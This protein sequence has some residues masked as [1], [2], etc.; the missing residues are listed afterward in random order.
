M[1]SERLFRSR[2]AALALAAASALPL[3]AAA[4]CVPQWSGYPGPF[5][6]ASV[7]S[8]ATWD[9]DGAAPRPPMIIAAGNFHTAGSTYLGFVGL[10]DGSQWVSL[11]GGTNGTADAVATYT[12]GASE[13]PHAIFGGWFT[14]A[15]GQTVNGL[16]RFDGAGWQSVGG[17]V[18]IPGSSFTPTVYV[19][20]SHDGWLI[21]SGAFTHA[22]N[23]HTGGLARW[24]GQQWHAF[25]IAPDGGADAL[26]VIDDQLYLGG[27]F[28]TPGNPSVMT[29]MLRW[30]GS[31]WETIGTNYPQWDVLAFAKYRGHLFVGGLFTNQ[32]CGYPPAPGEFIARLDGATWQPVGTGLNGPVRA[33]TVFDPDGPGPLPD[34]LIVGGAFSNAGGVPVN[35]IAAWNGSSW[36]PLGPGVSG[37]VR[38]MVIWRNQLA[39][40]GGFWSAGGIPS[41]GLAFW[42]C[43]QP[44]PC[45][46][47]CDQST[48]LPLL[49]VEDFTCF[50]N[51]FA[52][53][54]GLTHGQQ[55]MHYANC[56]N[57][58]TAPVLNVEDFTCFIN[59]FAQGCP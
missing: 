52:S 13:P 15:G 10:W 51:E 39:V 53:A 43:P 32:C 24:D 22:G 34:L 16:G 37:T 2:H 5:L 3:C 33:M 25:P 4:Q 21:A 44:Q 9:P 19:L 56:D 30:T 28:R 31:A 50:I 40:A 18:S 8:I 48:A 1:A 29:G 55:V 20:A 35:N 57:S 6:S 7:R 45:Y 59:R 54:T 49:N 42:G 14:E 17:G 41:P 26:S 12:T 11:A 27:W 23:T 38:A 46:A 58:T 36:Q 47:N